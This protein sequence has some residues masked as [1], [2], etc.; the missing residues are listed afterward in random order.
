MTVKLTLSVP[1]K[2]KKTATM[3]SKRRKKSISAL[4]VELLER[5]AAKEKDPFE[6]LAEIWEIT[7]LQRRSCVRKHGS[8]PDR[9]QHP[10]RQVQKGATV[11][12]GL[13][14]SIGQFARPL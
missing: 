5:E 14:A 10:H 3:L 2:F 4:V 1:P 6:K 8:G 11:H 7:R 9:Y 13:G 12:G